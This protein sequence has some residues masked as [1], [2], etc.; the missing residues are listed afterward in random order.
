MAKDHGDDNR[1]DKE[2]NVNL[3]C[4][5]HFHQVAGEATPEMEAAIAAIEAKVKELNRKIHRR[6]KA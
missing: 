2:L 3:R 6:T 1:D 5:I 4:D